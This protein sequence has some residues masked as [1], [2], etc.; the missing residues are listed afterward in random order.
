MAGFFIMKMFS[1]K[2]KTVCFAWRAIGKC[3][4]CWYDI[5]KLLK[6]VHPTDSGI[7]NF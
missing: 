7:L 3:I 4:F 6:S 5:D 1:K 2:L